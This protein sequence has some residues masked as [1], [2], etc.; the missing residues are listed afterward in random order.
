MIEEE[1]P[2]SPQPEPQPQCQPQ[3]VRVSYPFWGYHDLFLFVGLMVGGLLA[4]SL[5][6]RVAVF[7]LHVHTSVEALEPLAA[8]L[9][10]DGFIFAV[11]SAMF[12]LQYDQP[13]W[14]SLAWTP[15]R[16]PALGI[17]CAVS[18]RPLRYRCWPF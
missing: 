8:Q 5:L 4:S 9:L 7:A 3:P 2:P 12:R 11:L 17:A 14:R 16:I 13:F 1:Q 18:P 6:A 10:L 15:L